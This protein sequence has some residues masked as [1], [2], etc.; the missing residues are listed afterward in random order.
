MIIQDDSVEA[1]NESHQHQQLSEGTA[2]KLKVVEEAGRNN[3]Y[4]NN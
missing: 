4:T 1:G 2:A 3:L